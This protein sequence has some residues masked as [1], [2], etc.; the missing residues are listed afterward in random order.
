MSSQHILPDGICIG[1]YRIDSCLGMGGFGISYLAEDRM[2]GKRVVLKENFPHS[3]AIRCSSTLRLQVKEGRHAEDFEWARQ[4]FIREARLMH[5]LN[6]PGIVKVHRLFEALN[7]VYYVMSFVEG[8]TLE[9]MIEHH[10]ISSSLT[11]KEVLDYLRQ[12][13]HILDYIHERF[14]YHRDIKPANL[15]LTPEGKI[16]LIDFGLARNFAA[17]FQHTVMGT[18]CFYP[19]EQMDKDASH[20][21]WTD[22]YALGATFYCLL[23][24]EPPLISTIRCCC[25]ENDRLAENSSLL[26]RFRRELLQVLDQALE[27]DAGQRLRSARE[28]L[29]LLNGM[30]QY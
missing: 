13:L 22:I 26:S 17:D 12:S 1:P 29:K 7:T 19:P 27:P 6:H 24:G 30:E 8:K 20:G 25:P 16:V 9:D 5:G 21:P 23:L 10:H 2:E 28:C 11:Q 15:M 18:K 4:R 14:I 3:S